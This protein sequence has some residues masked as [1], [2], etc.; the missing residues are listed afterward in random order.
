[1]NVIATSFLLSLTSAAY[2][3]CTKPL[4]LVPPASY[5]RQDISRSRQPHLDIVVISRMLTKLGCKVIA[6]PN[7]KTQKGKPP[8]VLNLFEGRGDRQIPAGYSGVWLRN[9]V[10]GFITSSPKP[11]G[12]FAGLADLA[13]FMKG[14]NIKLGLHPSNRYGLTLRR[15]YRQLGIPHNI[16]F[17]QSQERRVRLLL[18]GK[19]DLIYDDLIHAHRTHTALGARQPLSDLAFFTRIEPVFLIAPQPTAPE[20]TAILE[21]L[22]KQPEALKASYRR[23]L[24]KLIPLKATQKKLFPLITSPQPRP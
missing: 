18:E 1:M 7:P 21:H 15:L 24:V 14:R 6:S 23:E 16:I 22:A 12:Q 8:L 20:L 11:P 2:G 17:N 9:K 3:L 10:Y 13:G 5:Q 4:V 19:V